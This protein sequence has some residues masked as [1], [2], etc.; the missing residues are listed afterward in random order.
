MSTDDR[1]HTND[2]PNSDAAPPIQDLNPK[3]LDEATAAEQVKGGATFQN[4]SF[5]HVIDKTSPVL[6]Q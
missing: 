2:V 6:Y 4:L 1:T 5:I 3:D